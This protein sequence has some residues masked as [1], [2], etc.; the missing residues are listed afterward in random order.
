MSRLSLSLL[1]NN[2]SVCQCCGQTHEV[3][4]NHVYDYPDEVE[5]ELQCRICLQPLVDAV[6]T[7]CCHTFCKICLS[8]HLKQSQSCPMD[9]K[10][11]RLKDVRPSSLLVQKLL[12][13]LHVVCPNNAYCDKIMHRSLLEQ[14]LKMQ[15]PGMYVECPRKS[16]GCDNYGPRC[17]LEEH[18]WSCGFAPDRNRGK[19]LCVVGS[20]LRTYL[21]LY[22]CLQ[23]W[24]CTVCLCGSCNGDA[25]KGV[26]LR[27]NASSQSLLFKAKQQCLALG[28][29]IS[30]P[31]IILARFVNPSTNNVL[32]IDHVTPPPYTHIHTHTHTLLLWSWVE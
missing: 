11:V 15:C 21:R 2:Y 12:D 9:R 18:L 22:V 7:P 13:K 25:T 26:T 32:K 30:I 20:Y 1:P 6:D 17:N 16:I 8:N 14:H 4:L 28:V 29:R 27:S 19:R 31:L 5:E 10:T 3:G 23:V 24:I